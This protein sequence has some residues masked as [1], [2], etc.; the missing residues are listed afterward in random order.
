MAL[1][2][3]NSAGAAIPEGYRLAGYPKPIPSFALSSLGIRLAMAILFLGET[4]SFGIQ[5]LALHHY[6]RLM[7]TARGA[8]L[9]AP[10]P[11]NGSAEDSV[12]C[13]AA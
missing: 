8:D 9:H 1:R 10:F 6:P 5:T 3:L 7:R 4:P 12:Y 13:E 2:H 11:F